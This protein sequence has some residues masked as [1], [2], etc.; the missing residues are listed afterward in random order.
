[1]SCI[2]PAGDH[3]PTS[4]TARWEFEHAVNYQ[5]AHDEDLRASSRRVQGRSFGAAPDVRRS[6]LDQLSS[7]GFLRN[8][9]TISFPR[10]FKLS[11]RVGSMAG[12]E[13]RL[14]NCKTTVLCELG[15][16]SYG[17]VS[18]LGDSHSVGTGTLLAVKAQT[19]TGM[20]AWEYE[21]L[22]R[23]RE[24]IGGGASTAASSHLRF[25]MAH[26]IVFFA[27]GAIMGLTPA[28]LES[29][30]S[31]PTA[32]RSVNLIDLVNLYHDHEGLRGVPEV[33]ALHYTAQMLHTIE[34]LHWK[35]KVLVRLSKIRN[36]CCFLFRSLLVCSVAF[37]AF[38]LIPLLRLC[39]DDSTATSSRTTGS[40]SSSPATTLPPT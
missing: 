24:R 39:D 18:L 10:M 8:Y 4:T 11:S 13:L 35:G 32:S 2:V 28:L 30:T 19:E 40:L 29:G 12:Q 20:L 9:P 34:T 1:V 38:I 36:H 33:L 3:E 27:D 16:G 15:R 17:V 37:T 31:T 6:L 7:Q 22:E 25:P 21:V 5:R 26:S 23:V 14:G